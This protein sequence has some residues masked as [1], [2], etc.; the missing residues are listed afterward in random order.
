MAFKAGTSDRPHST[1]DGIPY[2][3]DS[4]KATFAYPSYRNIFRKIAVDEDAADG[5]DLFL[6]TALTPYTGQ[7][8]MVYGG[9]KVFFACP[10]HSN[11]G[12]ETSA[13]MLFGLN[14]GRVHQNNKTRYGYLNDVTLKSNDRF[15]GVFYYNGERDKNNGWDDGTPWE[16]ID[17]WSGGAGAQ[18][19]KSIAYTAGCIISG[20]PGYDDTG[21]NVTN[22]GG[23]RVQTDSEQY[24]GNG[25]RYHLPSFY[26]N[27]YY[28][29]GPSPAGGGGQKG[30]MY[31]TNA[32]GYQFN[33][34][35][36][37]VSAASGKMVVGFNRSLY[38][39]NTAIGED[40]KVWFYDDMQSVY[41]PFNGS[42]KVIKMK[43]IPIAKWYH[44]NASNYTQWGESHDIG[45]GRIVVGAPREDILDG[46]GNVVTNYENQGA[47][48][49]F[50]YR[51]NLLRRVA[52]PTPN[53]SGAKGQ[54]GRNVKIG[55]GRIVASGYSQSTHVFDLDGNHIKDILTETSGVY[56][57]GYESFG[58]QIDVGF[59][60]IVIGA[61][62]DFINRGKVYLY[63]L[64]G[65]YLAS[66]TGDATNERFGSGVCLGPGQLYIGGQ[67]PSSGRGYCTAYELNY[68]R[69]IFTPYDV[70]AM[71]DGDK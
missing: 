50:D 13:G 4:P 64:D 52:N 11:A 66:I 10:R 70:Q 33:Y 65:N 34:M 69:G 44:D 21:N 57:G 68:G 23:V 37:S 28:G 31:D 26:G 42:G 6:N 30:G 67:G 62:S 27:Y 29:D 63:D 46:D 9:G 55:G 17:I 60:Y 56:L 51:G 48:Y 58:D 15:F 3:Y 1:I 49:I 54:F 18:A 20:A 39:P 12:Q 14:P 7:P 25:V 61:Y 38:K 71:E 53:T 36:A 5:S 59:G 41:S 40:N 2:L 19:N 35:G 16:K 8:R 32:S 43:D 47:I 24:S 22:A 45:C